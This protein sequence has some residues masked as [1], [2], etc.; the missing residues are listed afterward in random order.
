VIESARQLKGLRCDLQD[1]AYSK[2]EHYLSHIP[3]DVAP[4]INRTLLQNV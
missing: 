3:L 1:T 4:A 2:F